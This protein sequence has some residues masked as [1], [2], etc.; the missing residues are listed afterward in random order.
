MNWQTTLLFLGGGVVAVVV[1]FWVTALAGISFVRIHTEIEIAA[2]KE[3]VW[4]VITD[5]ARYGEWNPVMPNLRTK[6]ELGARLD[7]RSDI[8]GQRRELNGTMMC[9]KPAAELAWT[10]PVS[11][12]ARVQFWGHHQLII[13]ERDAS[14]VRFVNTEGFGG[15]ISLLVS[16]FLQN[17]V[18]RTYEAHNAALKAR[19]EAVWARRVVSPVR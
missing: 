11:S 2:P 7:W 10:G 5:F 13:E 19:A 4:A 12:F 3:V 6:A 15:V 16:E 14:R 9:V 18:R 17:D 1:G 8:G